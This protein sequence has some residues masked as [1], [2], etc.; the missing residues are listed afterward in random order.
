MSIGFGQVALTEV[1]REMGYNYQG[2]SVPSLRTLVFGT[3]LNP[4]SAYKPSGNSLLSFRGYDNWSGL[5]VS[6]YPSNY[7]SRQVPAAQTTFTLALTYSPPSMRNNAQWEV[8]NSVGWLSASVNAA[9]GTFSITA[10]QN[11]VGQRSA[12]VVFVGTDK[13]G[14]QRQYITVVVTQLAGIKTFSPVALWFNGS[15]LGTTFTATASG[16]TINTSIPV[17]VDPAAYKDYFTVTV[18]NSTTLSVKHTKTIAFAGTNQCD[19]L[20]T[21][22]TGEIVRLA[23]VLQ[24]YEA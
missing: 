5:C 18:V 6:G 21:A 8:R 17:T 16:F 2:V 9:G 14:V 1:A 3:M 22:T 24:G 23:I 7:V 15:T 20:V 12:S 19:I 11:T 10:A 4:N 13:N